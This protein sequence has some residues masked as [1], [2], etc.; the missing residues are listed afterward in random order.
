[1]RSIQSLKVAKSHP[2]DSYKRNTCAAY[3]NWLRPSGPLIMRF[4]QKFDIFII[5]QR[6]W[7]RTLGLRRRHTARVDTAYKRVKDKVEPVNGDKSDRN[8]PGGLQDWKQ[9]ALEREQQ[10]TL[11]TNGPYRE[12]LIPKFSKV[13]GYSSRLQAYPRATPSPDRRPR[14]DYPR[15][16]HPGR[17][18]VQSGGSHCFSIRRKGDDQYGCCTTSGNSHCPT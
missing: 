14:Y 7:I 17:G 15:K 12:W 6:D 11:E 8:I 4:S 18:A 1:M 13:F 16:R 3:R 2:E 9:R 10:L 5:R